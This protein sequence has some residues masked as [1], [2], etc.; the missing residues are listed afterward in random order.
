MLWPTFRSIGI[1]R[2]YGPNSTHK[3]Y[4]TATFGGE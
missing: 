2:A 3:W 4:W 1:G